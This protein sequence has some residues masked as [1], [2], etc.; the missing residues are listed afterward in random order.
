MLSMRVSEISLDLVSLLSLPCDKSWV[1]VDRKVR[2]ESKL[3]PL[4]VRPRGIDRRFELISS[5]M[6]SSTLIPESGGW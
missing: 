1:N 6:N 5:V 3:T 2:D 4:S